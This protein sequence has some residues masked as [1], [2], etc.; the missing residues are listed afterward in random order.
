MGVSHFFSSDRDENTNR[1]QVL[2]ISNFR[3]T[4][5]MKFRIM[6]LILI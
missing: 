3:F 1:R 6:L 2:S 5:F 4:K